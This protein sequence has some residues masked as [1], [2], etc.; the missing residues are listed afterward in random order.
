MSYKR[1]RHITEREAARYKA[2]EQKKK[3]KKGIQRLY[4]IHQSDNVIAW[5][6]YSSL[7]TMAEAFQWGWA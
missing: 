4:S 1:N 6:V 3:K 5:Y 7:A 2:T